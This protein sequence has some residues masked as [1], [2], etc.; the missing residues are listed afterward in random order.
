MIK[1]DIIKYIYTGMFF[2]PASIYPGIANVS[3][4]AFGSC[5]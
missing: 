2:T 1:G 4:F 3:L 5:V